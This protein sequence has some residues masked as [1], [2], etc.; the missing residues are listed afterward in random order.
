MSKR[1]KEKE[2]KKINDELAKDIFDLY[3]LHPVKKDGHRERAYSRSFYEGHHYV[4]RNVP[5]PESYLE[6]LSSPGGK[7]RSKV[8]QIRKNTQLS[9]NKI[10]KDAPIPMGVPM[11]EEDDDKKS[12]EV[13]TKLLEQLFRSEKLNVHGKLYSAKT[14][15]FIHGTGWLHPY[16]DPNSGRY[17]G[18]SKDEDEVVLR[19]GDVGLKVFDDFSFYPDPESTDYFDMR[20]GLVATLE[21][22]DDVK[23][24]YP[25]LAPEA[26]QRWEQT[27]SGS[28][29]RFS[30]DDF[31]R[32]TLSTG[33]DSYD[34]KVF[35][36]EYWERPTEK[37]EEGRHIVVLNE[38]YIAHNGLNIYCLKKEIKIGKTKVAV[39]DIYADFNL[40]F[41]P[42]YYVKLMD[43]IYGQSQTTDM[44]PL[45][46]DL[47]KIVSMAMENIT[48][49]AV[50]KILTPRGCNISAEA[51]DGTGG[52]KIE[53]DETSSDPPR[54]MQG[55]P[56][57]P[58]IT[59]F[60]AYFTGTIMDIAGV[61]EVS[62]GQL[63]TG[64]SQMSGTAL[65]MLT[66]AEFLRSQDAMK[67]AKRTIKI[68]SKF[69]L[70]LMK[71]NY[72][73]K[74]T[75]SIIGKD[76]QFS[77][78]SYSNA[79]LSGTVDVVFEI[80]SLLDASATAKTEG[81][82]NSWDRGI[83]QSASAGDPIAMEVLELLGLPGSGSKDLISAKKM[84]RA[85]AQW[86][87]GELLSGKEYPILPYDDHKTCIEEL[88]KETRRKEIYEAK[89]GMKQ[90]AILTNAIAEHQKYLQQQQAQQQQQAPP[91]QGGQA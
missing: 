19:E 80:G 4:T 82:F 89:D 35:V 21:S 34:D 57:P 43:S 3:S 68:L 33:N 54:Y 23:A 49:T 71:E 44:I 32:N 62:Q 67:H 90:I 58:G 37:H 16:W 70:A 22:K 40:P 7:H 59:D 83:M 9:V 74:R 17:V 60:R 1:K 52:E 63:P 50:N 75:I 66:D 73:E 61:H 51:F 12:A 29:H 91:Q 86:M 47:N 11:G 27:G 14:W 64:G 48:H 6:Y 42:D 77:Y 45:N 20:W 10:L 41:I 36:I 25:K 2:K 76:N 15:A 30:V 65:K 79:D 85:K 72:T 87:V 78:D 81:L 39:R 13:S 56:L 31:K 5:E 8:N 38:K 55:A 88:V 53:Y 26:Y 28:N 24:K 84:A 46:K 18:K 69:F